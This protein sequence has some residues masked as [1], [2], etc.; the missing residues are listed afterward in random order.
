[1]KNRKRPTVSGAGHEARVATRLRLACRVPELQIHPSIV[2]YLGLMMVLGAEK[3]K[4]H[5]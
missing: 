1:M 4:S 3:R 5:W 2:I